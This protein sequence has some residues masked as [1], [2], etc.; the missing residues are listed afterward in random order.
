[1]VASETAYNKQDVRALRYMYSEH[2]LRRSIYSSMWGK[3]PY[4]NYTR[5]YHLKPI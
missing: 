4:N 3:I 1:M 2:K 5:L